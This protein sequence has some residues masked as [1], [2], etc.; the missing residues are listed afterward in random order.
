MQGAEAHV[1]ERFVE[2][3]DAGALK[4]IAEAVPGPLGGG[5]EVAPVEQDDV[6]VAA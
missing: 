1:E 4:L 5:V 6:L 3:G 2:V